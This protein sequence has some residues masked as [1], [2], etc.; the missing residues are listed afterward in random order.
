MNKN[1]DL[2]NKV[3]KKLIIKKFYNF[4]TKLCINYFQ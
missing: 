1:N 4:I 2:M 3:R